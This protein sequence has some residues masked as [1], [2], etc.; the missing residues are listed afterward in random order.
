MIKQTMRRGLLGVAL[1]LVMML[2]ACYSRPTPDTKGGA[3]GT[4]EAPAVTQQAA[5][6]EPEAEQPL[7]DDL[8]EEG[9][10]A[11]E[12]QPDLPEEGEDFSTIDP[13]S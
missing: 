3:G 5:P 12:Q 6:E 4:D 8:P 1:A 7:P 10:E 2:T 9:S 11:E 13:T